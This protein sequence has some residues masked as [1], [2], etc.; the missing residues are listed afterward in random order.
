MAF[1]QTFPT[2]TSSSSF[3]TFGI[4]IPPRPPG[5][6]SDPPCLFKPFMPACER[7]RKGG[8]WKEREAK[9]G[10]GDPFLPPTFLLHFLSPPLFPFFFHEP[11]TSPPLFFL[12]L[13][14]LPFFPP[15]FFFPDPQNSLSLSSPFHLGLLQKKVWNRIYLDFRVYRYTF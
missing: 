4:W 2:A 11:M 9:G 5:T 15:S 1:P 10:E 13:S 12:S 14:R 7:G 8:S 6:E 3:A